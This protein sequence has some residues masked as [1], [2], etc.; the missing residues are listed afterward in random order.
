MGSL[1]LVMA[2]PWHYEPTAAVLACARTAHDQANQ[3]SSVGMGLGL[4]GHA[5]S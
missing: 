3:N 1:L 5:S 2:G 4:P